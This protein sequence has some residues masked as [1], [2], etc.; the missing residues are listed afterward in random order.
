M[1]LIG[2][3]AGP[4]VRKG[5]IH[6]VLPG[7]KRETL[8]PGGGKELTVRLTDRRAIGELVRKP[9]LAIG[10]LYMDKRL[11]IEGGTMLDLL[12]IV[13][14]SNPWEQ[15]S[16]FTQKAVTAARA[17]GTISRRSSAATR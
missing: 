13:L 14:S 7:G 17:N 3:F 1:S 10:E 9:R 16:R 8:G 15:G 2:R 11:V 12:E 6:V 5:K 4:L